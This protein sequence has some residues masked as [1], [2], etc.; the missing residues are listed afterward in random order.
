M[1]DDNDLVDEINLLIVPVVL[2]GCSPMPTRT[3]R[4]DPVDSRA[5]STGVTLQDYRPTGR[6][7][8]PPAT[9]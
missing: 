8:Y 5:D 9:T 3:S 2:P 6:P 4:L 7:Q 1:A